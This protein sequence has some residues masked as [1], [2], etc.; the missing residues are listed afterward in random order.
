MEANLPHSPSTPQLAYLRTLTAGALA[1]QFLEIRWRTRGGPMR[2][3][4]IPARQTE[5]AARLLG[6]L[7][8]RNDVY[9]GVALRDE[10]GHGGRAAVS[11]LHV[12]YVDCD[13][14]SAP[15]LASFA[16]RSSMLVAS[17]TPGHVQAYW[18]LD[19]AYPPG[20]VEHCNRRLARALAGD[21]AC[22]DAARIL[23]PAGTLNHKHSPPRPVALL[24]L[25]AHLRYTC[26]ELTDGLPQGPPRRTAA[27]P[28]LRPRR[29]RTPLDRELLAIPAAEYVRVLGGR[30]P[31]REGKL[32][33]PFHDDRDPSLQL[34]AD[35]GFY[36]FGSGCN[37]GGTI[38]DF[39]ARLWGIT[40]RGAGFIE[41]RERLAR[42]FDL[43]GPDRSVSPPASTAGGRM[44]AG[45][46]SPPKASR[47]AVGGASSP[48][49]RV[50]GGD[51]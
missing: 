48:A 12:A 20:E 47:P 49:L 34:Y 19:R 1:G 10:R 18:L 45:S 9:V 35:G 4:F 25:R 30:S 6:V 5:A 37:A 46:S 2:R 41:L 3:R 27:C 14:R 43:S 33:C 16:H 32:A 42:Q 21:P 7:A 22:T 23:R 17:G 8:P 11:A 13:A 51:P 29:G 26:A 44:P 31:N 39:A 50:A 28:P 38:F 24:A 15:R 36:C 40:P